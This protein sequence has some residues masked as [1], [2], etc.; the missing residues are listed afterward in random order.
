VSLTLTDLLHYV[1]LEPDVPITPTNRTFQL[2]GAVGA[3]MGGAAM[4]TVEGVVPPRLQATLH[5]RPDLLHPIATLDGSFARQ[6]QEELNE[7]GSASMVLANEDP[8]STAVREGHVIRF[9]DEGWAVFAWIVRE[10]E[11][12]AIA[13]G[14]EH[15]QTTTFT[16]NG[17]LSLLAEAVVYPSNWPAEKPVEED[18]YFSWQ[19][20]DYDDS[21]WSGS[22]LY[23]QY[24]PGVRDSPPGMP[25]NSGMDAGVVSW[26]LPGAWRITAFAGNYWL[27]PGG[28]S[29]FRKVID[30]TDDTMRY[31][32]M[33]IVADDDYAVW[34]DGTP[35]TTGTDWS[36]SDSDLQA[37]QVEVSPGR[38]VIAVAIHNSDWGP[39][40]SE[41]FNEWINPF[42]LLMAGWKMNDV[43][44][45][46]EGSPIFQTD[47]SWRLVEY[48]PGPPGWT[49]GEVLR[50]VI[51]EAQTRGALQGLRLAFTDETDSDGNPWPEVG[52]IATKVGTDYLTFFKELCETY[53]DMW[54]EP[55][56]FTLHAWV[57]GMRGSHLA[58]ISFHPVTD[59]L[60]PWSGN[61]AGLT[62]RRVD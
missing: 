16:G 49:P 10:I 13:P 57:K 44:G 7:T 1:A 5:Q 42:S 59:P 45:E 22:N 30:I 37:P 38:H 50:R 55:A 2:N 28:W 15:D 47:A 33:Y 12:A 26:P 35:V 9:E 62:Y 54:M 27:A 53:I 8:Q 32:I 24:W 34:F 18:R 43:T 29:Y 31:M 21:W 61:L 6:W 11:R 51:A 60:D 46:I 48:P 20:L 3:L 39:M 41:M 40:W 23:A 14:E 17:L 56:D 52:D 19:S 58:D 36:N 25:P 4:P